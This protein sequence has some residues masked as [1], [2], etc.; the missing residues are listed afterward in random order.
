MNE[1]T[2][3]LRHYF[4]HEA[5]LD[6]RAGAGVSISPMAPEP[7]SIIAISQLCK[8]LFLCLS[9]LGVLSFFGGRVCAYPSQHSSHLASTYKHSRLSRN[10]DLQWA[11]LFLGSIMFI[12][13]SISISCPFASHS[14]P[15]TP[16]CYIRCLCETSRSWPSLSPMLEFVEIDSP[17]IFYSYLIYF[18][19]I[20]NNTYIQT[21]YVDAYI[22]TYVNIHV[23]VY[24]YANICHP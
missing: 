4:L 20:Y 6:Y 21:L 13:L 1:Y 5:L 18:I 22:Y 14:I 3:Q 12:N 16:A 11:G 15:H 23:C 19:D 7:N 9:S 17:P 8:Y 24:I 2:P 10:E